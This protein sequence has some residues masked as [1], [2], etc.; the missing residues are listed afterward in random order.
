MDDF[1]VLET[2]EYFNPW[3]TYDFSPAPISSIIGQPLDDAGLWHQ[4]QTPF[5]CAVVSQEMILNAF[6]IEVSEAELVYEATSNGWLTD[7]GTSPEDMGNLLEYYGIGTH[8][9]YGGGIESLIEE[10][11]YGRKL[12]VGLD[13]GEIWNQDWFGEDFFNPDGADHA[14]MVTGMDMRDPGNPMVVLNDPGHPHGAGMPVPLEQFV[15]AWNDSG[16]IYVATD[17]APSGLDSHSL[18]GE[19]FNVVDEVGQYMNANYWAELLVNFD[20]TMDSFSL[21]VSLNVS[22]PNPLELLDDAA[23]TAL[24][25]TI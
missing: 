10:L 6:G 17:E 4:Q 3:D 8:T 7:H 9:V 20:Q 21:N 14:V 24:F 22:T 13:S 16:Q 12:I 18:F 23:R 15:D 2:L 11:R 5:T 1:V 19:N 25:L